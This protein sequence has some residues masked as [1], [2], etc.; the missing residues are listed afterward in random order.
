LSERKPST[1]KPSAS[2]ATNKP[3]TQ[4]ESAA[5][6]AA[7]IRRAAFHRQASAITQIII[8]VFLL[9]VIVHDA[10]R[11]DAGAP[12]GGV[13]GTVCRQLMLGTLGGAG[14]ALPIALVYSGVLTALGKRTTHYV[15]KRIAVVVLVLVIACLLQLF[16][17][18]LNPNLSGFA[19]TAALY[20]QGNASLFSGGVMGGFATH[21]IK[22]YFG[23]FGTLMILLAVTLLCAVVM[24][25]VTV[26]GVLRKLFPGREQAQKEREARKQAREDEKQ[27]KQYIHRSNSARRKEER[28]RAKQER[29]W[30]REAEAAQASAPTEGVAPKEMRRAPGDLSVDVTSAT[31][32]GTRTEPEL[33]VPPTFIP[34]RSLFG[35]RNGTQQTPPEA[36]DAPQTDELTQTDEQVQTDE[37]AVQQ[38]EAQPSDAAQP[39]DAVLETAENEAVEMAE[40]EA[41]GTLGDLPPDLPGEAHLTQE[42]EGNSALLQA[43]R[44]LYDEESL[45]NYISPPVTLLSQ[46]AAAQSGAGREEVLANSV[47]II[48]TLNNFGVEATLLGTSRGPAVTRYELSPAAGVKISRITNLSDDIALSLAAL[49]VR[50][51]APIPGKAAIGIEVPNSSI[52]TVHL[53]S[54]LESEAFSNAQS[55]LTFCLGK[56]IAGQPVVG[57][58][59]KMPHLLIAGAT[60]SGKSVCIN[61]MIISLLYKA[62]PS[63]LRLILIDPKVVEMG[64]Y[65]GIPHLMIPVVTD[66]KKAAGA[67]SWAVGEMQKRYQLF[68]ERGVKDVTSYNLMS[69]GFDDMAPLPR[70]VIVIDELADLMMTAP[71]EVED[72]IMRLAQMA[73]AAG[74]HLVIATQRPT[75]N[76]ITGTIKANV[77]SRIAF[78]VSS[79][80][81]SRTILDAMGAE[82]LLGRGD[83]L[84]YPQGAIKPIRVQGCYVSDKEVDA[85]VAAIK[86]QSYPAAYDEEVIEQIDVITERGGRGGGDYGGEEEG[87]DMLYAAIDCVLES[88]VASVSYLQ[89][90]LKLGYA[91]AARIMDDMEERGIVGPSEGSKPRQIKISALEWQEMKMRRL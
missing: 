62:K 22:P 87:D 7:L 14:F 45:A 38:A 55:A 89:R 91:R 84:Y 60:G 82:K 8:G 28:A 25:S 36:D 44:A 79:Q 32:D 75:V 53:R 13:V 80:I 83:M 10:V 64:S 77:P 5:D 3:S 42:E 1:K 37:Q 50:I 52:S 72:S 16:A 46:E 51:E 27:A 90:R 63:E 56:D 85:V 11:Q 69:V 4:K 12:L 34:R 43:E 59:A 40:N 58:I 66:P 86:G 21:L 30:A 57:D 39:E 76:V 48:E 78:A 61:S 26:E 23:L 54:I 49:G 18:P 9:A 68:A 17:P 41:G 73:R 88:G 24:G 15:G 6:K 65:N 70:I 2:K 81:D 19:A 35:R 33:P 47:K 74:M 71:G 31:T 29:Q 20:R 67:L